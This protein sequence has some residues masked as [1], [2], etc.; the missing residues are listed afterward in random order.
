VFELA[1]V[2]KAYNGLISE[3]VPPLAR[4]SSGG[5]FISG[6]WLV[7]TRWA[8]TD[9]AMRTVTADNI[10]RSAGNSPIQL[11]ASQAA[12]QRV[13]GDLT[14]ISTIA[15]ASRVRSYGCVLGLMTSV[16]AVAHAMPAFGS[17][18]MAGFRA[19]HASTLMP[20]GGVA[21]VDRERHGASLP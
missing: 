12:S 18:V 5:P 9:T 8:V 20:S 11:T 3:L 1:V 4:Q 17:R 16:Q 13:R 15:G 14:P 10:Q 2:A 21:T 19:A 7:A 6:L